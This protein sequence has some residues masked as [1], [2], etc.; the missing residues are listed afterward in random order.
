MI[1]EEVA[2][3]AA[4]LRSDPDVERKTRAILSAYR[5]LLADTAP[6]KKSMREQSQEPL[7][8]GA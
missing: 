6:P 2:K 3:F 4:L 1:E 8:A 7:E 5:K